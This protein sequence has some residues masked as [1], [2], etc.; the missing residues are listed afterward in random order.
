MANGL[1]WQV[2]LGAVSLVVCAVIGGA[3]VYF[4][5][6]NRPIRWLLLLDAGWILAWIPLWGAWMLSS[7]GAIQVFP[8]ALGFSAYCLLSVS[9]IASVFQAVLIIQKPRTHNGN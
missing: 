7:F 3:L 5:I 4:A 2:L 8:E 9:I 6:K 1:L